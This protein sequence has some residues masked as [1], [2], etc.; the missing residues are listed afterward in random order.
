MDWISPACFKF[1][2][3]GLALVMTAGWLKQYVEAI[4]L[5]FVGKDDLETFTALCFYV[6]FHDDARPFSDLSLIN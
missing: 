6:L 2:N 3:M 1:Q 4:E 5:R